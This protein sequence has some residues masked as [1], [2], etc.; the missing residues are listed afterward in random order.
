MAFVTGGRYAGWDGSLLVGSLGLG[1]LSRL[2]LDGGRVVREERVL[3]EVGARVRDVRQGP[4][5]FVYLLTDE[6]RGRLLRLEAA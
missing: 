5:G 1:L 6:A 2:V 3:Q 4:D